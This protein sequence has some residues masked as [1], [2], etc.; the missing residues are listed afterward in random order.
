MKAIGWLRHEL[1]LQ[2]R[3]GLYALY[4]V[5]TGC[6]LLA[7]YYVPT[8]YQIPVSRLLVLTDPTF[9]GLVFV[10][11]IILMEKSQGIPKAIGVSPLGVDGYIGGKVGSLLL[12]N[13]GTAM[14]LL[15][16][17]GGGV[18]PVVLGG[19]H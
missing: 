4:I 7:L 9:L 5:I 14:C 10:G 12:I 17:G 15:V 13:L 1:G 6:Y 3:N 8:P 18:R 2:W 16:A 11:A 19:V